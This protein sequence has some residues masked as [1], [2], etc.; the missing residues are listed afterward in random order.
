MPE[1]EFKATM[2]RILAE[3]KKSIEDTSKFLTIEIK[4]LKSTQTKMKME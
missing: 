3:L 2:I 4:D 1:P